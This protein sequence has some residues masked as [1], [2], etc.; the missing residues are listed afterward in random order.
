MPDKPNIVLLMPDQQRADMLGSTGDPIAKTPST[1]RLASEGVQFNNVY[2]QGPLCMPARASLLT[3]RYVRDHG[4]FENMSEVHDAVPTYAQAL[5]QAGYHTAV[6]GKTHFW[7]H[8]PPR[9]KHA[10]E[11]IGQLNGYGFAEVLETVGKE[12]TYFLNT[13]YTDFLESRDLLDTYRD[14]LGSRQKHKRKAAP[15]A[16]PYR[17]WQADPIPLPLDA[18]QDAWL[19]DFTAE[20]LE[21]YDRDEPFFV[22]IG[23]PGPHDPWDAP[24]EAVDWYDGADI[25]MPGSLKRPEVPESGP[26]SIFLRAFLQYCDSETMTDEAIV[27]LRRAYYANTSI[28]DRSI[29]KIVD[30]LE[31]TGRLENTWV[32]YTSD[33]GEMMGEHRMI[34][35]MVFFDQAVKV[36]LIIRPPAGTKAGQVDDLIQHMDISATIRDIA[37]A[38]LP[39]SEGRS[40]LPAVTG[41]GAAPDHKVAI[42]ESY[43]MGMFKT[44]RYKLVVYEDERTP[45]QLFDSETDP[46]EDD[47]LVD[48]PKHADVVEG[49]MDEHV[50]PFLKYR[51]LRPHRSLIE[52]QTV[53]GTVFYL[54]DTADFG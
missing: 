27:K 24:Q 26:L 16:P 38:D 54:P 4:V 30:A 18:Y 5:Q 41:E 12:A 50:L 1:D 25:P 51:P 49:M 6:I 39:T 34:K 9:V 21:N 11:R 2:V 31:R 17:A 32:I 40:L 37:G 20:W 44:D 35:K 7:R 28:I 15:D 8:I 10:D 48:D 53:G 47:N 13:K 42:S 3:E 14:Y 33:H 19:G 22:Q 23:F 36:P 29:G 45:A 52:R 43:G 46:L